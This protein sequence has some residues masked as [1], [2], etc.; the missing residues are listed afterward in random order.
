MTSRKLLDTPRSKFLPYMAYV[1]WPTPS[2]DVT[3]KFYIFDF[4]HP[5]VKLFTYMDM[6]CCHTIVD[7][8]LLRS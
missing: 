6:Y 2:K 7:P 1:L 4:P 3:S 8:L 5:L